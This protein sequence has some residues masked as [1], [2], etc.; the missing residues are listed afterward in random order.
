[1]IKFG[2]AYLKSV[3]LMDR[4]R[5]LLS[6]GKTVKEVAAILKVHRTTIARAATTF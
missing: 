3:Q 5:E 6:D 4:R 1:L 2:G